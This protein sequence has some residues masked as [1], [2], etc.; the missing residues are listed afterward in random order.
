MVARVDRD[1]DDL[2]EQPVVREILGPERVDLVVRP[3]LRQRR[4]VGRR[5]GRLFDHLL[6]AAERDQSREN[7]DEHV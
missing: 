3:G 4:R 2:P 7:P 5:G 1:A 6:A